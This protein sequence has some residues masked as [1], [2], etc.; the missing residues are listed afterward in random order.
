MKESRHGQNGNTPLL[1][2][3]PKLQDKFCDG[4]RRGHTIKSMCERLGVGVGLFYFWMGRGKK[5]LRG[6]YR[7]FYEAVEQAKVERWESQKPEL[8]K[9]LYTSATTTKVA[10][11]RKIERIMILSREDKLLLEEKF[12]ES[13]ELRERFKQDGVLLK[14]TVNEVQVLPNVHMAMRIL[15]RKSPEEWGKQS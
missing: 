13:D 4:I 11:N 12:E 2:R 3:D 8:E 9:V 14:E 5:E 1:V 7:E 10:I 15:E 6:L